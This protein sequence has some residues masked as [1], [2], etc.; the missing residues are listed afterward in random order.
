MNPWLRRLRTGRTIGRLLPIYAT[1][2]VLKRV[3]PLPRLAK[4]AW[5]QPRQ[6]RDRV[7][8]RH[9]IAAVTRLRQWVG[10]D[11]DCLQSSLLL[12]RELSRLG[13]DP[14]LAVGFRRQVNRL[15]GHAWVSIDGRVLLEAA[16]EDP[17]TAALHFGHGGTLMANP[18]PGPD[19]NRTA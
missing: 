15:E 4:R 13:A 18:E 7:A 10:R 6:P 12:Y 5:Q 2:A 17:F 3:V 8:E 11:A 19:P 9:V 1:Y 16:P 14:V